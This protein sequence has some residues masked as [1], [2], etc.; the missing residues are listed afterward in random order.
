MRVKVFFSAFSIMI[1]I[2]IMA[3]T[4]LFSDPRDIIVDWSFYYG[5]ADNEE[6]HSIIPV[7]GG[8]YIV[9]GYTESYGY[10]EYSKPDIWLLKLDQYGEVEWDHTYGAD[11]SLDI[12][13]SVIQ[14]ADGGYI[15]A[16][17]RMETFG[18]GGGDAIILKVDASGTQEWLKRYGGNDGDMVRFISET[19]DGGYIA[20]GVT[21]SYGAGWI[22]GWVLKIDADGNE[23]WNALFGGDEYEVIKA[24]YQTEDG[25]YIAAGY[26]SS[27]GAGGNDIWLLKLDSDGVME[28]ETLYGGPGRD[29]AYFLNKTNDN[30]YILTGEFDVNGEGDLIVMKVDP[31]GNILWQQTYDKAADDEGHYIEQTTD[32]GYIVA[33]WAGYQGNPWTQMW[34]LKLDEEG[35]LIWDGV[36]GGPASDAAHVVRKTPDHGFIVGGMT[37]SDGAGRV[38]MWLMKFIDDEISIEENN[39]LDS[40]SQL[41]CYPNPFKSSLTIEYPLVDRSAEIGIYNISGQMI[42][43]IPLNGDPVVWDGKDRSGNAA[44]SGLYFIIPGQRSDLAKKVVLIR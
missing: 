23:E 14:T 21:R 30:N 11:D 18:F 3:T 37:L 25:G 7:D 2:M 26:T 8:G 10:G 5:G 29:R 44:A 15:L 17:E 41:N 36:Y 27:Q 1:M 12:A 22:D 33:A 35:Q 19:E 4:D 43:T 20:C 38:D 28:W 32:N 16:G 13:Y 24:I 42:K 34:A 31:M 6:A 39:V 40:G 9:A